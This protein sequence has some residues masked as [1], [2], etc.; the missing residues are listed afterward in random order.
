MACQPALGLDFWP[1]CV[2]QVGSDHRMAS[3]GVQPCF[4]LGAGPLGRRRGPC[5]GGCA[6]NL[7]PCHS[8]TRPPAAAGEVLHPQQQRHPGLEDA[9]PHPQP[10]RRLHPGAGRWRRGAVPGEPNAKALPR[11]LDQPLRL[12]LAPK[13]PERVLDPSIEGWGLWAH[14]RWAL[15]TKG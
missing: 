8:A 4:L 3:E 7:C 10:R 14:E 9:A 11:P 13:P 6:L 5:T 2:G 1:R 15:S 12:S